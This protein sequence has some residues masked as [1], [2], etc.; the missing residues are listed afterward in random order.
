MLKKVARPTLKS[1]RTDGYAVYWPARFSWNGLG[2][3]PEIYPV[4]ID[5]VNS[6]S[7]EPG[8]EIA[9]IWYRTA[10]RKLEPQNEAEARVLGSR[11][12]VEDASISRTMIFPTRAEAVAKIRAMAEKRIA[13]IRKVVEAF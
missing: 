3:L 4:M 12:S 5:R 8:T 13:D 9:W 10:D 2:S 11:Q 6:S 7:I 1:F